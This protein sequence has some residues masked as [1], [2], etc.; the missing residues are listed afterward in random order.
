VPLVLPY[1]HCSAEGHAHP[2]LLGLVP[3][4]AEFHDAGHVMR[5][6]IA[7][8]RPEGCRVHGLRWACRRH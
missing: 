3:F 1:F 6:P 4:V 5:Q 7:N 2:P 8:A